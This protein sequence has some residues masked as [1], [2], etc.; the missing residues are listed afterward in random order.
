MELFINFKASWNAPVNIC[1]VLKSS[2]ILVSNSLR[3]L[4]MHSWASAGLIWIVL[5]FCSNPSFGISSWNAANAS[6]QSCNVWQSKDR[7]V[8]ERTNI[9]PLYLRHHHTKNKA[10]LDSYNQLP[11]Y[12]HQKNFEHCARWVHAY[13]VIGYKPS[14]PTT[15]KL[16]ALRFPSSSQ[17]GARAIE[18]KLLHQGR[19]LL[20]YFNA[21]VFPTMWECHLWKYHA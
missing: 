5:P 17:H 2:D 13:P 16:E 12:W 18:P 7:D 11:S 3:N 10:K 15:T 1:A 9:F 14:T 21:N 8:K 20:P 6:S 19:L 4:L